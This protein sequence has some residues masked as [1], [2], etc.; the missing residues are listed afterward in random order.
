LIEKTGVESV[1]QR[2][3]VVAEFLGQEGF[4]PEIETSEGRVKINHCN[5][6]FSEA[7]RATKL[8]CRLEAQ[9]FEQVLQ[10]KLTRT[11]Y[12]PDG[13]AACVYEFDLDEA[14]T[15]NPTDPGGNPADD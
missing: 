15:C 1:E 12:M 9:L 6:P 2:L 5:C 7:V 4:M 8:P 14:P 10:R 13:D 11:G 3:E